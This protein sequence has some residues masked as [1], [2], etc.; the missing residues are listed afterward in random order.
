MK[1]IFKYYMIIFSSI[2]WET[3]VNH[4]I[5]LFPHPRFCPSAWQIATPRLSCG[6]EYSWCS[7]ILLSAAPATLYTTPVIIILA[8]SPSQYYLHCCVMAAS[9][10]PT[11]A[12]VV[13]SQLA[14]HN[15]NLCMFDNVFVFMQNAVEG[16]GSGPVHSGGAP[17]NCNQRKGEPKQ[18]AR[19]RAQKLTAQ[20]PTDRRPLAA[21]Q[22]SV[23]TW[24][25]QLNLIWGSLGPSLSSHQ[26]AASCFNYYYNIR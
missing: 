1:M 17:G 14:P 25:F 15:H 6:Y 5:W 11:P 9:H 16:G 12:S 4:I 22:D 7:I 3:T 24:S 13:Q 23:A 20:D 21:D 19:H 18:C 8:C 26:G 10:W 2:I